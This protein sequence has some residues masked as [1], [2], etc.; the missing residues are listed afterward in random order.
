MTP[1]TATEDQQRLV[2]KAA[3]ALAGAGLVHA[4]GH[5]SIRLDSRWLLVCAPRP[6]GLIGVGEAGQIAAIEGDLPSGVLQRYRSQERNREDALARL[7][8]L[9]DDAAV[10][11]LPRRATKPTRGS[12]RR[13]VEAKVKHGLTKRGRRRVSTSDA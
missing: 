11:P 4:Y 2:R 1:P 3:R 6:M 13:R 10:V 9:V 5:C 12:Q 8:Q 7:Q